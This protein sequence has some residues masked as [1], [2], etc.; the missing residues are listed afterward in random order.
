METGD[1]FSEIRR[2]LCS[3]YFYCKSN[4]LGKKNGICKKVLFLSQRHVKLTYCTEL[5]VRDGGGV[6][7]KPLGCERS[8]ICPILFTCHVLGFL[9]TQLLLS[10]S[11]LPFLACLFS[12]FLRHRMPG[13]KERVSRW[14]RKGIGII[15]P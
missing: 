5:K 3:S 9:D 6:F 13:G 11:S 1:S 8:M 7:I 2:D 15:Q 14:G 4:S 12:Y 10:V